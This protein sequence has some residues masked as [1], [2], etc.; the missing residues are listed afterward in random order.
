[1]KLFLSLAFLTLLLASCS[2]GSSQ[3]STHTEGDGHADHSA[4]TKPASTDDAMVTHC[5][6]MPEMA[7]CSKYLSGAASDTHTEGSHD[8]SKMVMGDPSE[9]KVTFLNTWETSDIKPL[10][11]RIER[12]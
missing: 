5:Q 1:M 4:S 3:T 6:S 12:A 11:F 7:G 8:M 10:Q 9:Y 2:L